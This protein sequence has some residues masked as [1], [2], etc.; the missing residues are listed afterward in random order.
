MDRFEIGLESAMFFSHR[1]CGM[2][3]AAFAGGFRGPQ[4]CMIPMFTPLCGRGPCWP[5]EAD[6]N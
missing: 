1:S 4:S 6:L 2:G 5:E 3:V